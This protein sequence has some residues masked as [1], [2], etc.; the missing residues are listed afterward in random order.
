MANSNEVLIDGFSTR[1][2]AW[3]VVRA[4][5][6]PVL[7]D[8]CLDFDLPSLALKSEQTTEFWKKIPRSI[9]FLPIGG[10]ENRLEELQQIADQRPIWGNSAMV[11]Q[12]IRDPISLQQTMKIWQYQ[13]LEVRMSGR[14]DN[15][16]QL[17]WIR[18][19]RSATGG[20]AISLVSDEISDLEENGFYEQEY[21]AGPVYSAQFCSFLNSQ[22]QPTEFLGLT[23][24]QTGC[25][26]LPDFPFAYTGTIGTAR[27]EELFELELSLAKRVVL[28]IQEIGLRLAQEYDLRGLWGFDFILKDDRPA[29][30]EVNPRYTA[31][32]EVLELAT[33]ESF[34]DLLLANSSS[35]MRTNFRNDSTK[36][37]VIGK[38]FLFARSE[39][40]LSNN[41]NWLP[42]IQ[43]LGGLSQNYSAWEIPQISD[44][45]QPGKRFTT[46]EPICTV[47]ATGKTIR[48]CEEQLLRR[49]LLVEDWIMLQT[50]GAA[51]RAT[52]SF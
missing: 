48:N 31:A 16:S 49:K 30:I 39:L 3:S 26:E 20:F 18:K 12:N 38:A 50:N 2:A 44:L 25:P 24:Q 19:S 14:P 10:W 23:K 41:W 5:L 47:W 27:N 36:P 33:G 40:Q 43:E 17:K 22:P 35:F 46:G 7:F 45:P 37:A 34:L 15:V 52:D 51:Y 32:M 42:I 28:E 6:R 13:S 11:M 8:Q 21:I 4:G 9:P 1:A 29:V